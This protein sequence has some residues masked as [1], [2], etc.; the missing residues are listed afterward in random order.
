VSH[1][2]LTSLLAEPESDNLRVPQYE[3]NE[4]TGRQLKLQIDAIAASVSE[5]VTK[6]LGSGAFGTAWLCESGRVIK[7]TPDPREVTT[8]MR[9]RG[10]VV[11]H[12]VTYYGIYTVTLDADNM[13]WYN[14]RFLLVMPYVKPLTLTQSETWDKLT[15][16]IDY[17]DESGGW[18]GSEN[19]DTMLFTDPEFARL[20]IDQRNEFMKA[21]KK[22][23]IY[24]TEVHSGNIGLD[25]QNRI[26]TFDMYT[27]ASRVDVSTSAVKSWRGFGELA[28]KFPVIVLNKK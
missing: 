8:A 2:K 15:G 19:I 25:Q 27:R 24:K 20:A 5:V 26:T 14:S 4:E 6:K 1:I 9:R 18:P 28:S 12:V 7:L 3:Q 21:L 23:N 13:E 10:K 16:R 22:Y 11:P 17:L